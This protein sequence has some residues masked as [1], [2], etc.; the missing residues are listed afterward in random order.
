VAFPN[1]LATPP[2]LLVQIRGK[3]STI[4]YVGEDG[5]EPMT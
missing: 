5:H 3:L 1:H 4:S 2:T